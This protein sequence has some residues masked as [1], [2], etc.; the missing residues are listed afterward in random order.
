MI[1][2]GNDFGSD[3]A[4][5]EMTT[6]DPAELLSMWIPAAGTSAPLLMA[7]STVGTD[8]YPRLRHVLLS[9]FAGG[10]VYFHTDARSAK[11][12][13]IEATPR[14]AASVAWPHLGRQFTLHGDVSRADP[15]EEKR[16]YAHRGRYLQLL[17]WLNDA[18]MTAL[19]ESARHDAWARFDAEHPSLTPPA[20]WVG[21]RII[22]T[23]ITFWRGDPE[24]PSQRVRF[25]ASSD[26]W[27]TEVLPG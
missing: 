3:C 9:E 7:L 14:A 15:D 23:V 20:D 4:P 17:A 19:P 22:P 2:S 13:E 26:G 18:S 5:E 21:Y 6:I 8:G 12:A 24:G 10:A 11:V 16:I 1:T 27:R 25:T